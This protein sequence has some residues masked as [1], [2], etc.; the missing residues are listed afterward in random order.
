MRSSSL[1]SL[2]LPYAQI[3][4][5]LWSRV[6]GKYWIA[7]WW[8]FRPVQLPLCPLEKKIIFIHIEFFFHARSVSAIQI[9]LEFK[10]ILVSAWQPNRPLVCHIVFTQA[11]ICCISYGLWSIFTLS[12]IKLNL[13]SIWT[14]EVPFK[15]CVRLRKRYVPTNSNEQW[16]FS[17]VGDLNSWGTQCEPYTGY[18]PKT[19]A[20]LYMKD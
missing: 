8:T 17:T 2:R 13:V 14:V 6:C 1:L 11:Q 18:K 19:A 20:L 7:K 4:Y 3:F 9:E 5:E 12:Q 16:I 10:L 15:I